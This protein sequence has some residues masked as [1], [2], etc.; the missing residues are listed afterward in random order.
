MIKYGR[1]QA[2]EHELKVS[3][4][5]SAEQAGNVAKVGRIDAREEGRRKWKFYHRGIRNARARD[6]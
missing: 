4:R 6:S 1:A 2:E 3:E 5:A